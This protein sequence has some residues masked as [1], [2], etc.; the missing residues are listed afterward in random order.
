VPLGAV[1]PGA[2]RTAVEIESHGLRRTLD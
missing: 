1:R 2:F